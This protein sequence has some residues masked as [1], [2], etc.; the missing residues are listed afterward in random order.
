MTM[1]AGILDKQSIPTYENDMKQIFED[2]SKSQEDGS[3]I[4]FFE[5][6]F[7]M[8]NQRVDEL[9]IERENVKREMKAVISKY[10]GRLI[11]IEQMFRYLSKELG[12][13]ELKIT[14]AKEKNNI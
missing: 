10:Q 8:L 4:E 9:E 1:V 7:E 14:E 6:R 2:L 3:N 11:T 5:S 12:A 13:C